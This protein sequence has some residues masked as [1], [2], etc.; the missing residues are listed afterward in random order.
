MIT[1]TTDYGEGP[2]AGAVK[3]VIYRLNPEA[4]VVDITHGVPPQD[5][6]AGAFVLAQAVRE[7]P[8]AV[9]LCIVDPGVGTDRAAIVVRCAKGTLVGPDNGVLWPAAEALGAKE[10]YVADDPEYWLPKVSATFHGR[11]VFAPI[12]TYLDLGM[13]PSELGRPANVW[14]KLGFGSARKTDDSVTGEV[15]YVDPFGNVVTNIAGDLTSDFPNGAAVEVGLGGRSLRLRYAAR[16]ADVGPKAP[17]A[18]VGSAG[19]LEFAVRE[20]SAAGLFGAMAGAPVR[21]RRL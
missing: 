6:R 16:F 4:V 5:V 8:P 19:F 12:A 7:F 9:H 15:I 2:Y 20:G 14:T 18:Y 21:L 1:L 11:D 17:L 10:V 13:E 3:G